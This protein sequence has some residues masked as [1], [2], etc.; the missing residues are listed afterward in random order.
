MARPCGCGETCNCVIEDGIGTDVTG[1]GT[2]A[3]PFTIDFNGG[4]VIDQGLIWNAST[5]KLSTK[6]AFG[7]GLEFDANGAMRVTGGPGPDPGPLDLIQPLED[8]SRVGDVF[9][10]LLGAGSLIAPESFLRSYE[11]GIG[12]G[13]DL[14]H[15]AVRYLHDGNPVVIWDERLGRTVYHPY[16][17]TVEH[18]QDRRVEDQ[19]TPF[20]QTLPHPAGP[21]EGM[22][23][24][25]P[26]AGQNPLAR[27]TWDPARPH[28]N[29]PAYGWFGYMEP[30]QWGGV[31][32]SDVLRL[33]RN[34]VPLVLHLLFPA[35]IQEPTQ[36][37]AWRSF[38]FLNEVRRLIE[39]FRMQAQVIVITGAET[40][41]IP[42]PSGDV[43][44]DV[45]AHFQ[46][47]AR[48]GP[49]LATTDQLTQY[50]PSSFSARNW[51]WGFL[52]P[53]ADPVAQLKPY[54]DAGINVLLS[55]VNR[56][57]YWENTVDPSGVKGVVSAD[58]YYY[59]G[60]LAGT[61]TQ[62]RLAT[63]GYRHIAA[64]F[65]DRV[66]LHGLLN[67]RD[68]SIVDQ[69]PFRRGSFRIEPNNDL[70]GQMYLGV[71]MD[72]PP[73]PSRSYWVLQGWASPA[74][75]VAV[76]ENYSINFNLQMD[77]DGG[78]TGVQEDW[79]GLAFS[80]QTDHPF[81]DPG[82]DTGEPR[83]GHELDTG[84]AFYH[85]Q[86]SS[87]WI[88]YY[89]QGNRR[90]VV[91]PFTTL[92]PVRPGLAGRKQYRLCVDPRGVLIAAVTTGGLVTL[93]KAETPNFQA[94]R[95]NYFFVG[96]RNSTT[97][98]PAWTGRFIEPVMRWGLGTSD[99]DEA[100]GNAAAAQTNPGQ[101]QET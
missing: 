95:G 46:Q 78:W 28:R 64:P 82:N 45:L 6:L 71:E 87:L 25:Q 17:V 63:R 59:G 96:R 24:W 43:P 68:T 60:A 77:D 65:R 23:A 52:Y 12:S 18:W 11:Y 47:S 9:C 2:Q 72:D 83:P 49:A 1:A 61:G 84:Y 27:N 93:G 57:Y 79:L 22:I 39:R 69:S 55:T 100:E 40:I 70:Q 101:F 92:T 36:S 88:N 4:E 19:T 31:L 42:A 90:E 85:C 98:A 26:H 97:P 58:P 80:T 66:V 51:T 50:P 7:G 86:N 67:P 20:W 8:P 99:W 48:I 5:R 21:E 73:A 53:N 41:E 32:L 75:N 16:N 38:L 56:Q 33:C 10:G 29:A 13:V 89:E 44:T 34:N 35:T 54:A 81:V 14:M 62:H 15:V 76:S 3:S 30:P 74:P 91:G 94:V 37:P